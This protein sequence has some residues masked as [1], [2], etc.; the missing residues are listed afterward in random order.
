MKILSAKQIKD[1][2]AFTIQNEPIS[3]I[4]LMERAAL[5]FVN[6]FIQRYPHSQQTA[7]KI[8]CGSGNNGGDGLA[9]ARLLHR[10]RYD[11][12]LFC[13]QISQNPSADF[14]INLKKLP[15]RNAIPLFYIKKDTSFPDISESAILID[16]IFGA[17]L[18][19]PIIDYWGKLITFLNTL[20]NTKIAVD[21]PSGLFADKPSSGNVLKANYTLSFQLPKLAFFFPENQD[22]VGTC[23]IQPIGLSPLFLAEVTTPFYFLTAALVQSIRRSRNKFDHKG[24]Y[25]HAL[26]IGG[27]HGKVGAIV[28]A[29]RACLKSGAG[30]VTIHAPQCA[31]SI[32]QI[33]FPEAMVSTDPHQ[34]YY[35][36]NPPL[37]SYKAIGIGCG[38]DQKSSSIK[39][40]KELIQLSAIPLV[41]DADAL[42]I[43]STNKAWLDYLPANSVLTP[44][45]KEFERLFGKSANDFER[46][47]LQRNQAKALNCFIILKG[48]NTCIACPDGTCYFN[49]TGNPGMA[50]GG[51]GDVL[52]GI[53]TGLL[54]QAYPV[55]DACFLGVYLHGLAGDLA[56]KDLGQ[57]SLIASDLIERLGGAFKELGRS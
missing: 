13:C 56:A 9:I 24:T 55:K 35:S 7:I 47:E 6:W 11:V 40:L 4:Q 1:W 33:S 49:T 32:L 42:N 57:E 54:A 5:A 44:R 38:L 10:K 28:L 34:Y 41:L 27:S 15:R 52:T 12:E 19:R 43:L 23:Y 26:L 18:N 37:T 14:T 31:Y 30:L 2:D 21:I 29:A 8:F 17:G 53:I 51:S 36:E 46:N 3:S 45:P 22:I 20:P 39:A 25:G 48:A 50:T 16:A